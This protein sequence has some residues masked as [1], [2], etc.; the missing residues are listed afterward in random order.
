[1]NWSESGSVHGSV[2]D[3]KPLS[4]LKTFSDSEAEHL[5]PNED[6]LYV[7]HVGLKDDAV[8]CCLADGQGGQSGGADAAQLAVRELAALA[9]NVPLAQLQREQTWLGFLG[10]ADR[11]V[12]A[13]PEAGFTTLVGVL[14]TVDSVVGASCGD[15]AA[16]L[17][18]AAGDARILTE[19]QMK[20]PPIGSGAAN[21]VSFSARLVAPW[22]LLVMS[23]GVWKFCG[24]GSVMESARNLGG[25]QL[26]QTLRSQAAGRSGA[27]PD[28]F[29]LISVEPVS[30]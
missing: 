1:V 27:L 23:D 29:S 25:E 8:L 4:M 15:S 19:R 9:A 21:P 6:A 18:P 5:G 7:R 14:V 30:S 22:K 24:L 28:D 26:F 20:N 10:L 11:K 16:I 13:A 3:T 2:G 12:E 17:V